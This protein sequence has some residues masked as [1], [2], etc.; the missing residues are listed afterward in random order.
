MS[1]RRAC[2]ISPTALFAQSA[3]VLGSA[4]LQRSSSSH[5]APAISRPNHLFT[6]GGDIGLAG[7]VSHPPCGK[8]SPISTPAAALH[9]PL[10]DDLLRLLAKGLCSN[11]RFFLSARQ[12]HLEFQVLPL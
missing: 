3:N 7:A 4:R 11:I 5:R 10:T 8:L 12:S 6:R 1:P 9:A 2:T